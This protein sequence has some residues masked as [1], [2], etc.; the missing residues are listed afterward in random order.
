MSDPGNQ[1][2]N[3]PSRIRLLITPLLSE[4]KIVIRL[5]GEGGGAELMHPVRL[6]MKG[7]GL[8]LLMIIPC[9][10]TD[11]PITVC[12]KSA[13]L[14]VV[15]LCHVV[16]TM[17]RLQFVHIRTHWALQFYFSDISMTPRPPDINRTC[18]M[19]V[20]HQ[21]TYMT[22]RYDQSHQHWYEF[23]WQP[24]HPSHSMHL[25]STSQIRHHFSPPPPTWDFLMTTVTESVK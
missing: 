14:P 5:G 1:H 25:Q 17:Q 10:L 2:Y 4:P 11:H 3:A 15:E 6:I 7:V 23:L 19:G 20:K 18:W 13:N 16:T 22:S 9:V 21:L 12:R 8:F 24:L